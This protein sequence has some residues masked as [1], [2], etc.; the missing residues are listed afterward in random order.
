M[1]TVLSWNNVNNALP[2]VDKACICYTTN[3]KYFISSMYHPHDGRGV[4]TDYNRKCWKGSSKSTDTI[5]HWAYLE[6]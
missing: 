6:D 4:I 2:E 5:S 1:I 3:H